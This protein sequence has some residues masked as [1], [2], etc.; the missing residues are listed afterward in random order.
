MRVASRDGLPIAQHEPVWLLIE[1][2]DGERQPT[3]FALTTLPARMSRR[4][5]VSI[6]KERYRTEK[7]YEELKGELGLDHFEGRRFPGWH[8]HVTVALSC[9]AFVVAERA[10]HFPPSAGRTRC[11]SPFP[12]AA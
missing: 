4:E 2:L 5:I 12:L 6:Y 1:W 8:H 10:R 3:K 11:S 9:Y 7:V